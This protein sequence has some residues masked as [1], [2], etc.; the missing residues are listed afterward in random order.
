MT[1]TGYWDDGP[2]GDY[3]YGFEIDDNN[4][5]QGEC[6]VQLLTMVMMHFYS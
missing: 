5:C 4:I 1:C 3:A 6:V 2:G